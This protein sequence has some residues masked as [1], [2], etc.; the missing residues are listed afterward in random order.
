MAVR[1]GVD[2]DAITRPQ[3]PELQDAWP[4][5]CARRRSGMLPQVSAGG[6]QMCPCRDGE[7]RICAAGSADGPFDGHALVRCGWL[8]FKTALSELMQGLIA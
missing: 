4:G 3:R 5:L 6:G 2:L 7:I 1:W 8:A